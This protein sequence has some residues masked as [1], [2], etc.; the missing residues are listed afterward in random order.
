MFSRARA[1]AGGVASLD[2]V[3]RAPRLGSARAARST[4]AR[5]SRSPRR[6]SASRRARAACSQTAGRRRER[7]RWRLNAIALPY[8]LLCLFVQVRCGG[9][10]RKENKLKQ[11][12]SRAI[13]P[14]QRSRSR[15]GSPACVGRSRPPSP[16]APALNSAPPTPSSSSAQGRPAL[17]SAEDDRRRRRTRGAQPDQPET[18]RPAHLLAGHQRLDPEDQ[19]G[20]QELLHAETHLHGDRLLARVKGNGPVTKNPAKA[21]LEG[22]DTLGSVTKK[23]DSWF[24]GDEAGHLDRPAGDRGRRHDDLLHVRDPSVHARL[25]R[26]GA[27]APGPRARLEAPQI[28]RAW[29]AELSSA[30]WAAARLPRP[31]RWASAPSA[32]LPSGRS[33]AAR[34]RPSPSGRACRSRE[35]LSDA[36]LTIPIREAEVQVL[37]GARDEDVD[38]RRDFPRPDDP[39]TGRPPHQGH[40]PSPAAA[41]G[42]RADRPP[43]RRPQPHPVRRPA[44]RADAVPRTLLLLRHPARALAARS[45]ATT[46]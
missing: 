18:G 2:R 34:A 10:R 36:H 17:R 23:G 12:L 40:L 42:G 32:L 1:A 5:S 37:P 3:S 43:A 8:S 39:A 13:P 22:W 14:G 24:T 45:P 19:E 31:C 28:R 9:R 4:S 33:L 15:S 29:G 44:G 21:G 46:C 27:P 16:A 38:L 26:S 25:D 11:R 30:P 20:A 6:C 7:R 41:L 35:V